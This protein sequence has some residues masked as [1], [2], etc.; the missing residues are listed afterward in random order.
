MWCPEMI[1]P[2]KPKV[3]NI[4]HQIFKQAHDKLWIRS[5]L[6]GSCCYIFA[7]ATL[8]S[9]FISGSPLVTLSLAIVSL[10]SAKGWYKWGNQMSVLHKQVTE[11][12][13]EGKEDEAIESLNAGAD[14]F[15]HILYFTIIQLPIFRIGYCKIYSFS[16]L[17]FA[18]RK[19]RT[20]VVKHLLDI[21]KYPKR[22]LYKALKRTSS[23][24]IAKLLIDAGANVNWKTQDIIHGK[25]V[26]FDS[27]L[28]SHLTM[29]EIDLNYYTSPRKKESLNIFD[30]VHFTEPQKRFESRLKLI[31]FL[32]A[33]NAKIFKSEIKEVKS[34]IKHLTQK[35]PQV[36][37]ELLNLKKR[38][39][40]TANKS[41]LSV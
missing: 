13:F 21:A 35:F 16:L 20:K 29:I 23:D 32:L 15:R 1:R 12:I 30:D 19:N 11:H 8:A 34:S 22:E 31:E 2:K 38:I 39:L 41:D 33:N 7:G 27:F 26:K 36:K 18:A 3:S 4:S 5:L 14:I 17:S 9:L 40:E 24:E 6:I 28:Y 25:L 10:V 37:P